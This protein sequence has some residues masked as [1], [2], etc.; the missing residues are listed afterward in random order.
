MHRCGPKTFAVVSQEDAVFSS[1][2]AVGFL[3]DSVEYRGEIA[4]RAVDNPQYLGGRGLLLQ[5][6]VALGTVLLPLG[7]CLIEPP[8]Q[9]SIGT[10]KVGSRVIDCRGHLLIP[11]GRGS[12]LGNFTQH[13]S[14]TE[15]LH[16]SG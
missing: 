15:S 4:R 10:L 16:S 13:P 11:S 5:G 14:A 12:G 2:K 7:K 8:L 3:Q 1:A 6:L 9:L